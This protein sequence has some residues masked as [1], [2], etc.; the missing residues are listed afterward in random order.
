MGQYREKTCPYCG[1]VHRKKGQYCSRSCGNHRT[2]T[3]AQ[4]EEKSKK[5]TEFLKSD[6]PVAE[7]SRWIISEVGRF[8]RNAKQDPSMNE[9]GWDDYNV[10]PNTQLEAGQFVADGAIWSEKDD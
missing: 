6:S 9:K 3:K 8:A 4:R 5:Q 2:Y 7:Q 10:M 1:T